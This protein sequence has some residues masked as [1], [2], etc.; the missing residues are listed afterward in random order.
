MECCCSKEI[1]KQTPVCLK[2]E[3]WRWKCLN[4]SS[5]SVTF[6]LHSYADT[7]DCIVSFFF[8][9]L[10]TKPMYDTILWCVHV[11][12]DLN[13]CS[14]TIWSLDDS[15]YDIN[16]G[17]TATTIPRT[18]GVQIPIDLVSSATDSYRR[19]IVL[20]KP[21]S[22]PTSDLKS[23]FLCQS[24]YIVQNHQT[25]PEPP[26]TP[27][28]SPMPSSPRITHTVIAQ[29]LSQSTLSRSFAC[30]GQSNLVVACQLKSSRTFNLNV[31]R[32]SRVCSLMTLEQAM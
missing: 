25:P 7:L 17:A 32:S 11:W 29:V 31:T 15:L 13:S 14:G 8:S 16:L 12:Y 28:I 22:V 5:R 2:M 18:R 10:P 6:G 23:E 19:T 21:M 9:S 27:G 24:S 4:A 3:Q 30:N 26:R 20:F 1:L